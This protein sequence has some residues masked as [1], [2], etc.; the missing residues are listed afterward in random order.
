MGRL[1]ARISLHLFLVLPIEF[2]SFLGIMIKDKDVGSK[3]NSSS[4]IQPPKTNKNKETFKSVTQ[5]GYM[6]LNAGILK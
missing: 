1:N 3:K 4:F 6:V 5:T 2:I